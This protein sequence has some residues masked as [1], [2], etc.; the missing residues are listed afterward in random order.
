MNATLFHSRHFHCAHG[1][2]TVPCSKAETLLYAGKS[3]QLLSA[4]KPAL[5]RGNYGQSGGSDVLKK[6]PDQ[7]VEL[8]NTQRLL[9][10]M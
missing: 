1:Y 8:S 5:W 9:T 4:Y 10:T 3:E 6:P 7:S 2:Q